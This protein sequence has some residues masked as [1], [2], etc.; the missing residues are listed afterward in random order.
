MWGCL[1]IAT[2][3]AAGR[4]NPPSV[5]HCSCHWSTLCRHGVGKVLTFDTRPGKK[6]Y[7]LLAQWVPLGPPGDPRGLETRFFGVL[8]PFGSGW[9]KSQ[10]KWSHGDPKSAQFHVFG[11]PQRWSGLAWLWSLGLVCLGLASLP[12]PTSARLVT[13]ATTQPAF[14]PLWRDFAP[15]MLLLLRQAEPRRAGAERPSQGK[16]SQATKAKPS[17]TSSVVPNY[18]F[19]NFLAFL[20][21]SC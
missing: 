20:H 11:G 12:Q 19:K 21:P 2:T 14:G 1:S 8:D 3:T 4:G 13:R 18:V 6:M 5:C 10:P 15:P 16:P 17:Q 9:T 7:T